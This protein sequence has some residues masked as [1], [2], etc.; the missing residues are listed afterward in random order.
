M[1]TLSGV[2]HKIVSDDEA[3][4]RLDRWIKIHYAGLAYGRLSKLLRT[5]QIRLD[6]GRV[7]ANQRLEAGQDI[8]VPPL[9]ELGAPTGR[10]AKVDKGPS[11]SERARAEAMLI[12]RDDHILALN[13]E[14]G[15]PTQGGTGQYVHVDGL[16]DALK[17]ECPER[18][19]LVHRLDKDTSGVLLL[20]RDRPT[21]AKLT[22]AFRSRQ[23]RKIY[24]AL[25]IGVPKEKRGR[26]NLAIDKRPAQGGERVVAVAD[27]K[28]A[29][30][31]Y[32]VIDNAGRRATWIA[33]RPVTGRTHQLRVH[34][35][36]IG[37]PIVGDGKYG[38][39]EAFLSG[40][41][42]RKLHLHAR[43]IHLPGFGK[44]QG[45]LHVSA[46]LPRHMAESW[47]LLGFEEAAATAAESAL[48]E[49]DR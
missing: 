2:E 8:R 42:S 40:S 47:E 21:A 12:Y 25:V 29:V 45:G 11:E 15:L 37:H 38:G 5:G 6:G 41:V 24:W 43:S 30:S 32:Q 23:S 4:L 31:Y 19:R 16:L 46:Q 44:G 3:G 34:L 48:G 20:A 14:P 28:R 49:F 7:K 26:I 33:L 17:F 35:A 18:P 22:K 1:G 13:K 27:G 9:G 36:E 10:K 39:R